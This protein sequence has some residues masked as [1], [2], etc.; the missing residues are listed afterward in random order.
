MIDFRALWPDWTARA[1][2]KGLATPERDL[3]S[4]GEWLS[5]EDAAVDLHLARR[6]C[7][8]CPVRVECASAELALLPKMA[9]HSMRGGLLPDEL[10]DLAKRLGMPHRQQAQCGTRS[11]YVAGCRCDDC[12]SAHATYE[13]ERR[14]WA[15]TRRRERFADLV[16]AH[17]VQ[18]RGR[19][20]HRASPGQLLLFTDGLPTRLWK[21]P[22]A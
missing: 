1:A 4:P 21:D 22:A 12:R 20:K 2:C 8:T 5:P 3:W 16:F 9:P 17:L 18:P 13:H 19:G 11:K 15:K 7:S 10:V 14:L 6:I